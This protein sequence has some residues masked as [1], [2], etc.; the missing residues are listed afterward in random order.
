MARLSSKKTFLRWALNFSCE[1]MSGTM[2]TR[3]RSLVDTRANTASAKGTV[4]AEPRIK[5]AKVTPRGMVARLTV[6]SMM[7]STP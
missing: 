6:S 1:S 2:C 3:G 4:A 5:S 7:A